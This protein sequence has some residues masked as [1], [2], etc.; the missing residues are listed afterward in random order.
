MVVARECP[1]YLT[2]ELTMNNM[3]T[4]THRIGPLGRNI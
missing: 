3:L 2:L 1:G 4:Q